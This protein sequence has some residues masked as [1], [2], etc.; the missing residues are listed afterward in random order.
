MRDGP[1]SCKH[2]G[3]A[4]IG[5]E[6]DLARHATVERVV[7][8]GQ[9]YGDAREGA[10]VLVEARD[11]GHPSVVAATIAPD[12]IAALEAAMR[13]RAAAEAAQP[14]GELRAMVERS[15]AGE[16]AA[17]RAAIDRG[18]L[19]FFHRAEVADRE[20]EAVRYARPEPAQV[21][22]QVEMSA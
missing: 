16:R 8:R 14:S 13:A 22:E 18:K 11:V 4:L 9:R 12:E 5:D 10:T 19:S 15:L 3:R 21:P 20:A 6:A 1:E 17:V 2:C 7:R